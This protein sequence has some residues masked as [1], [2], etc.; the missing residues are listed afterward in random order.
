MPFST[1]KHLTTGGE[2]HFLPQLK[3]AINNADRIDLAVSFIKISGLKYIKP[4]LEDA[5]EAG[6]KVRILTGDYLQI[7]DPQSLNLLMLLK[8]KGAE[9]KI[10]ESGNKSFHPKAYIFISGKDDAVV[11]GRVFIGSSNISHS[12]LFDGIEWNIRIEYKE[13]P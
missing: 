10:F 4:A 3:K 6:V 13:N 7:T 2:D 11:D 12:A 1:H 5:I 9:I 8:E